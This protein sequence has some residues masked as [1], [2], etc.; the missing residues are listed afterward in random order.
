MPAN[1]RR[2]L[3]RRLKFKVPLANRELDSCHSISVTPFFDC[4]F[5]SQRC[6]SCHIQP[7]TWSSQYRNPYI[8]AWSSTSMGSLEFFVDLV[9]PAALWPYG[10]SCINCY[11][12]T[13]IVEIFHILRMFL[14]HHNLQG[15]GCLIFLSPQFLPHY[16]H[17][18]A[19]SN[20]SLSFNHAL[21][22][23]F[24]L[25]LQHKDILIF[26]SANYLSSYFEASKPFKSFHGKEFPIQV[27]Q[28][29]PQTSSLSHSPSSV[30][31]SYK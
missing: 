26:H 30:H 21:Q 19:P 15:G 17:F 28:N 27:E 14:I 6:R 22:L 1:G 4:P 13:K 18:T 10:T 23:C 12:A 31:F 5:T 8:N 25:S 9:L 20:L 7:V 29:R 16:F 24:F 3:I 11:L 2:D